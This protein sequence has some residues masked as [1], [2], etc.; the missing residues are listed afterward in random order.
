M[1]EDSIIRAPTNGTITKVDIKYGELSVVG[2]SA[3]VLQDVGN[4][5]V[6]ADINESN[7]SNLKLGQ[8]ADIT[9]DA[10]TGSKFTGVIS[11][12]D[13]SSVSTDGIVNYKIKVSIIERDVNIRPGMNAEISIL[14]ASKPDVLAIPKAT[15]LER[16]GK[17]FVY[18][19]INE[20]NKKYKEIEISLGMKG[21]GS[22][23][24]IVSGLSQGDKIALV[25]PKK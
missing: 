13:P 8:N 20:K 23:V 14:V 9:I 24:E 19:I 22:M 2:K 7:I 1:Y 15:V 18:V 25:A 6:E 21:D 12:I 10:L 4:L 11:H 16:N 17:T 3:I 5:Y